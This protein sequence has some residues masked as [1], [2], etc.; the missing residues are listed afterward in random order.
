MIN[1]SILRIIIKCFYTATLLDDMNK[2]D[3]KIYIVTNKY[4]ENDHIIT[5]SMSISA[6]KSNQIRKY[7][8]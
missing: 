1:I 6:F 5:I 7:K 3:L 8:K 2:K 4:T